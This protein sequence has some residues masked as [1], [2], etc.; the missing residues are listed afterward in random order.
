MGDIESEHPW[1]DREKLEELYVEEGLSGIE[2]AEKFGCDK[3]TI[4]NWL[5]KF[6]IDVG[7]QTDVPQGKKYKNKKRLKKMYQGKGMS[8]REIAEKFG[9]SYTTVR[10]WLNKF[11]IET[12]DQDS[13]NGVRV[14]SIN[15]KYQR[16]CIKGETMFGLHRLRVLEDHSLEELEDMHVHHKNGIKIDNR[17]ENLELMD[18]KKHKKY[19]AL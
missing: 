5:D 16:I 2:I 3:Q 11:N 1:R 15:N 19:H 7:S 18:P 8:I 9:S 14:I 13:G 6:N 10:R 12:R 17:K 4:Y